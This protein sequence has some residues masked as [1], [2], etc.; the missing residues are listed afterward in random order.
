MEEGFH[1]CHNHRKTKS[2]VTMKHWLKLSKILAL[3]PHNNKLE[4]PNSLREIKALDLL[5][6]AALFKVIRKH[7]QEMEYLLLIS[8]SRRLISLR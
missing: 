1:I 6:E 7:N 5:K 4:I 8:K 3:F 2:K